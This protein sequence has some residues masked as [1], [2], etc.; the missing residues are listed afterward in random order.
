MDNC[1]GYQTG[2]CQYGFCPS[3]FFFPVLSSPASW[4]HSCLLVFSLERY[5]WQYSARFYI[6]TTLHTI[7]FWLKVQ[8]DKMTVLRREKNCPFVFFTKKAGHNGN[9]TI[10]RLKN[11]NFKLTNVSRVFCIP[12]AYEREDA[13]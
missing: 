3:L 13:R 6:R 4:H 8:S 11:Y 2:N 1:H 9:E 5:V 7:E 12:L 10:L